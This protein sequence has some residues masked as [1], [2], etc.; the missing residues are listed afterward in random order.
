[1]LLVVPVASNFLDDCELET[2]NSYCIDDLSREDCRSTEDCFQLSMNSLKS[3]RSHGS[4]L[5]VTSNSYR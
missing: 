5:R 2:S 3:S 1:V 4:L